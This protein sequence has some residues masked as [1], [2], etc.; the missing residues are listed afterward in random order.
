MHKTNSGLKSHI[1]KMNFSVSHCKN[2]PDKRRHI[3]FRYEGVLDKC[4]ALI[5][6]YVSYI[7]GL[8]RY[9]SQLLRRTH[10]KSII[11][12]VNPSQKGNR[13]M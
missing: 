1:L 10:A 9:S 11:R 12:S 6:R 3:T 2:K 5:M 7:S 8:I 13:K 4:T